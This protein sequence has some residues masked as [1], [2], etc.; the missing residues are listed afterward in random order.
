VPAAARGGPNI[1]T[2][3]PMGGCR[4]AWS[5]SAASPPRRR[6]VPGRAEL[7]D[8]LREVGAEPK[9]QVLPGPATPIPPLPTREAAIDRAVIGFR[10]LQWSFWPLD[11]ELTVRV[12]RALAAHFDDLFVRSAEGYLPVVASGRHEVLITWSP[13]G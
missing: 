10:G 3:K 4:P 9:V 11:P 6:L 7:V 12:Q 8:V 5:A 13:R 1:V 2:E